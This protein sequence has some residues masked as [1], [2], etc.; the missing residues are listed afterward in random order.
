MS[1]TRIWPIR[2]PLPLGVLFLL[3]LLLPVSCAKAGDEGQSD[4]G[5]GMPDRGEVASKP[6]SGAQRA[7]AGSGTQDGAVSGAVVPP[8]DFDRK[9]VKTAEL[10]VHT[11][12]QTVKRAM[13]L[14]LL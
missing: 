4:T 3:A 1:S 5:T 7:V 12:H 8:E 9:I 6:A 11:R 13:D 10:G 2:N 14:G